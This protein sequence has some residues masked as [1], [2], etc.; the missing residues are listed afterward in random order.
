M[1]PEIADAVTEHDEGVNTAGNRQSD[2]HQDNSKK[3]VMNVVTAENK[4]HSFLAFFC[5]QPLGGIMG[6]KSSRRAYGCSNKLVH[7]LNFTKS[8]ASL[9]KP[10]IRRFLG[11]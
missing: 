5:N 10:P 6:K 9:Q 7:V 8:P 2:G 1:L 4:P 3:T 11:K